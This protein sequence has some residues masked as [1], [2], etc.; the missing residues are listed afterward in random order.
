MVSP[1]LHSVLSGQ[2]RLTTC[3]FE[4]TKKQVLQGRRV[5]PNENLSFKVAMARKYLKDT[6]ETVQNH[7]WNHE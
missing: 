4:Y 6:T 7:V 2:C 1:R 5:A 3:F